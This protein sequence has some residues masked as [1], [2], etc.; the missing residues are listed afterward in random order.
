MYNTVLII[1]L[2]TKGKFINI[3]KCHCIRFL[4]VYMEVGKIQNKGMQ[5]LQKRL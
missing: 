3:Q 1:V 4:D 2:D 5:I